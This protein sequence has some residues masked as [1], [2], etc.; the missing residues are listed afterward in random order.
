MP[1]SQSANDVDSNL[2]IVI[3]A[4]SIKRADTMETT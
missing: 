2:T 4:E 3:N 1:F